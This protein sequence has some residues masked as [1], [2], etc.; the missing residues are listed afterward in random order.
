M[1]PLASHVTHPQRAQLLRQL[2]RTYAD[3]SIG[4]C[5]RQGA[6]EARMDRYLGN[7]GADAALA[8]G[9]QLLH[10]VSGQGARARHVTQAMGRPM[11]ER[12]PRLKRAQE[13]AP[14]LRGVERLAAC[15]AAPTAT[16]LRLGPSHRAE[17]VE[18]VA[19]ALP[20]NELQ[21]RLA[22][23]L[24]DALTWAELD[25]VQAWLVAG[26]AVLLAKC[27]ALIN[28]GMARSAQAQTLLMRVME[29]VGAG[30][31]G[32]RLAEGELARAERVEAFLA[33]ASIAV[34]HR[35][36]ETTGGA[37]VALTHGLSDTELESALVFHGTPIGRK[38]AAALR[39]FAAEEARVARRP[40]VQ[41]RILALR[42]RL[43][44]KRGPL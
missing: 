44:P 37:I 22:M 10:S 7:R 35:E 9:T 18:A 11:Q 34:P 32:L 36:G 2:E 26:G 19:G 21:L 16:K 28:E 43:C 41:G 8:K 23:A 6:A 4:P 40:E 38:L 12:V 5:G 29:R 13:I 39:R 33:A 25:G 14:Q 20:R 1:T 15:L 31:R 24:A 17:L 42:D 30:P 3:T 27:D